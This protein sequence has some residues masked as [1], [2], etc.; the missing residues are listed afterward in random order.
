MALSCYSATWPPHYQP[1][2][3]RLTHLAQPVISV[4]HN[5]NDKIFYYLFIYVKQTHHIRIHSC[6]L[7]MQYK[8]KYEVRTQYLNTYVHYNTT[9]FVTNVV[10]QSVI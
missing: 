10:S 1:L 4:I 3:Y 6:V 7:R 8:N 9:Q 2:H 5:E